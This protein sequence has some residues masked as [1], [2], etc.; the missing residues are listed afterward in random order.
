M[1][2]VVRI[3]GPLEVEVDGVPVPVRG[4]KRRGM[5]A[6]LAARAITPTSV[7][8]LCD[9]IWPADP[10]EAARRSVQTYV[11]QF[12]R[13]IA[14]ET[15]PA[16]YQLDRRTVSVDAHQFERL[17]ADVVDVDADATSRQ[18]EEALAL[19]R[20]PALVEFADREWARPLAAHWEELRRHAEDE[21]FAAQRAAGFGEDVIV[22]LEA[23]CTAEPL[24]ESRWEQLI[25]ALADAGRP[26]EALRAYGRIRSTLRDEL[27]VSPSTALQ[28]LQLA[29]LRQESAPAAGAAGRSPPRPSPAPIRRRPVLQQR[30]PDR[31]VPP[32]SGSDGILDAVEGTPG[33]LPSAPAAAL[34][35]GVVT[36][37]L[38]DVVGS[39]RL[40]QR[41]PKATDAALARHGELISSAVFR[42]GGVVLKARGE[43]DSTFSVFG[44][45]SDAVRAAVDA[46]RALLAESWPHH[47]VLSVRL[48]VHSGEAFE[49]EG[50]YF[51]PAVNRAARMRALA[52]GGAV[53]LSGATADLASDDLP[54]GASLVE[55]G[56]VRLRDVDRAERV[57]ALVAEGIRVPASLNTARVR[58][59]ATPVPAALSPTE[60]VFVGRTAQLDV[61]HEAWR[62]VGLGRAALLLISGEPGIGKTRLAGEYG[63]Q[64][65]ADGGLVLW[66]QCDADASYPFQPLAEA[67][68]QYFAN[69]ADTELSTLGDDAA[70]LARLV[71]ELPDRL[72]D[73]S[74][75]DAMN[76][77]SERHRLFQAVIVLMR[78]L[79]QLRGALLVID[80]IQWASQPMVELLRVLLRQTHD[81]RVL[82]IGTSRESDIDQNRPLRDLLAQ[83]RTHGLLVTLRL[84][85]LD[86][87]DV[88]SLATAHGADHVLRDSSEV[89]A[90]QERTQGNPLFCLQ[91][92]RHLA[93][94]AD[95]RPISHDTDV[96]SSVPDSV[97]ELVRQ[98]VARLQ[99]GTD[100]VLRAA[101]VIGVEFDLTALEALLEGEVPGGGLL[102]CLEGAI[103]DGLLNEV[104]ERP[105]RFRFVHALV[106]DSLYTD[107]S[108]AR[109]ARLHASVA[110]VLAALGRPAPVVA[111]HLEA[112]GS[113]EVAV[114]TMEWLQ[115][116]AADHVWNL[117]FEDAEAALMRALAL[118]EAAQP[119]DPATTARVRLGCANVAV[120]VGDLAGAN[121]WAFDAANDARAA[122]AADLLADA[123]TFRARFAV[124]GVPD[125]VAARLLDEALAKFDEGDIAHR[126]Q[127]LAYKAH[128]LAVSEGR[129]FTVDPLASKA[130]EL[131]RQ[132]DDP[133]L[134]SD[135]LA[136]RSIILLGA[137]DLDAQQHLLDE[138]EQVDASLPPNPQLK[139]WRHQTR[140]GLRLRQRAVIRL[141]AG[142]R[143]GFTHDRTR[144][145]QLGE[146]AHDWH[147]AG[148]AAMWRGVEN[149][150][151]GRFDEAREAADQMLELNPDD[152]NLQTSW[153]AIH[154]FVGLERGNIAHLLTPLNA[155]IA[156]APQLTA[157]RSSLALLQAELGQLEAARA[158]IEALVHDDPSHLGQEIGG[159]ATLAN[160]AQA[161][162]RV[163]DRSPA[164]LL[165]NALQPYGG[166]L[167]VV[168]WGIYA[169]GA[170]D[171]FLGMLA[172]T[173][174]DWDEAERRF[175][176]AVDLEEAVSSTPLASRT[177]TWWARALLAAGRPGD[178]EKA[179]HLLTIAEPEARRLRMDSLTTEIAD[180]Q[181]GRLLS[182]DPPTWF[183]Q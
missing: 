126:A 92:L 144:L 110:H 33:A 36:L 81:Q 138:L 102:P 170:A 16:G 140:E 99:P 19:W 172:A 47:F 58:P 27:G 80:D 130:V 182:L 88:R 2:V 55:L 59:V 124:G 39:T 67:L 82:I 61:L 53:V 65:I 28:D 69:A 114:E 167:L 64:V 153:A 44:R 145:Q 68:G 43:G 134:L 4:A 176:A 107:M 173:D 23:A 139:Y 57:F 149:L 34:P 93:E 52:A 179:R 90:L 15:F 127:V 177:R 142:D 120:M 38:T 100:L 29:L 166:Q 159:A 183:R 129:G 168:A 112:A 178:Y 131:A 156:G 113:D 125:P 161:C 73:L 6:L 86:D 9:A 74:T 78:R 105:G 46:Q 115:R 42:H 89:R 157:I 91:I 3:L 75:P 95:A 83:L 63:R 37:L 122:G 135:T 152:K 171:R 116:A 72:P 117:A 22:R 160:L 121:T 77:E 71:P 154:L 13:F 104:L 147:L 143:A 108:A 85:G 132:T 148:I 128:Y 54:A 17:V 51:G 66:G 50:D 175:A 62:R 155:A 5:L 45:A 111:H 8:G 119:P 20:G 150:L 1:P 41:S 136:V 7:D 40:W 103:G 56:T 94:S 26:A 141:R 169:P 96:L 18:L 48:A 87:A 133:R 21:W 109:R 79:A 163:A 70:H 181:D 151:D 97:R 32:A 14:V 174:Q 12:R 11:S 76:P 31:L 30:S 158:T 24:R 101:A 25:L 106:H 146:R 49:R 84:R 164:R 60:P 180:L 137:P 10:L 165:R 123:A 118:A 162:A 98:R 35:S